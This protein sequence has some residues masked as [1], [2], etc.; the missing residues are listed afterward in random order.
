MKEAEL[1]GLIAAADIEL[2][3][4][5]LAVSKAKRAHTD[6]ETLY[7]ETKLAK[8][9]LCEDLRVLRMTRVDYEMDHREKGIARFKEALPDILKNDKWN[10]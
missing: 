10:K 7:L 5:T 2:H 6:A 8:E 3:N 4:A 1:L 9:R